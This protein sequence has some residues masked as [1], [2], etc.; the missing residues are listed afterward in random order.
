M[1]DIKFDDL[2]N[3]LQATLITFGVFI[4]LILLAITINNE[5]FN[6]RMKDVAHKVCHNETTY[7][8]TYYVGESMQFGDYEIRYLEMFKGECIKANYMTICSD[9][10]FKE[11]LDVKEVC[12]IK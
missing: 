4:I 3:N 10:Y 5:K 9:D 11:V 6:E 2:S 8:R 7:G 12:E 1:R